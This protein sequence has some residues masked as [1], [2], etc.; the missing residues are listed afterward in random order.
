LID[1]GNHIVALL[2][3][4]LERKLAGTL[5]ISHIPDGMKEG[6]ARGEANF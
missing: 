4:I 3:N 2:Q 5:V 1:I 6:D